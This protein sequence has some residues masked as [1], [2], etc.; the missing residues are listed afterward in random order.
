METE[1]LGIKDKDL[2]RRR[3]ETISVFYPFEVVKYRDKRY[4]DGVYWEPYLL[5]VVD[6]MINRNVVDEKPDI[7]LTLNVYL[8][9][10]FDR[11]F[12]NDIIKKFLLDRY[13]LYEESYLIGLVYKEIRNGKVLYDVLPCFTE[14]SKEGEDIKDTSIRLVREEVFSSWGFSE[15]DSWYNERFKKE[16]MAVE[17]FVDNV[18]I[19][20][21][22]E[23][24]IGEDKRRDDKGRK[25]ALYLWGFNLDKGIKFLN[26]WR[27]NQHN[28]G[29]EAERKYMVD[30][31][32]IWVKDILEIL[33]V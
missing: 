20:Y 12:D 7:G 17:R 32:I 24:K 26:D 4:D 23:G 33:G 3:F 31:C 6:N 21:R 10:Q 13:K 11:Y 30:V 2:G 1:F 29:T 27:S 28:L 9:R 14:T 16:I 8:S 19:D 15:I 5:G 18:D 22:Y 25:V